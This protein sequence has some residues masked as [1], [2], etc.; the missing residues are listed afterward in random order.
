MLDIVLK[1]LLTFFTAL[2]GGALLK[3]LKIPMGEILGAV[4]AVILLNLLTPLALFPSAC[5]TLV[6]FVLGAV[7]ASRIGK[8]DVLGIKKMLLPFLLLISGLAVYTVICASIMYSATDFDIPTA[9]LCSAPG[10]MSD[11]AM[12]AQDFGASSNYV[13]AVHV[14]RSLSIFVFSPILYRGVI[15][16]GKSERAPSFIRDAVNGYGIE[17]PHIQ[18]IE[19]TDVSNK[20]LATARTIIIAAVGGTIFKQL[21][22]PAGAMIGAIVSTVIAN[23]TLGGTYV[24]SKLKR[25]TRIGVGC[26]IGVRLERDFL[27]NLDTLI[28]P[29]LLV[30]CGIMLFTVIMALTISHIFKF[31]LITSMLMCIPGGITEVSVIAEEFGVDQTKIMCVHSMR[32]ICV[33]SL[34]PNLI[35]LLEKIFL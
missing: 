17:T 14:L 1:T 30:V 31:D 33:V 19:K 28:F 35:F 24:P 10:G 2:L 23:L 4:F 8:E 7:V 25:Y 29:V 15:R 11:M 22:V 27:L 3:K 9:L 5:K 12:I 13:S 16:F 18:K 6:Q 21:G 34:F 26:Y 32:L 20:A